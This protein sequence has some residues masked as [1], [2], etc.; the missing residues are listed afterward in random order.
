MNDAFLPNEARLKFTAILTLPDAVFERRAALVFVRKIYI[1]FLASR[2]AL[3]T[4]NE[5]SVWHWAHISLFKFEDF[6]RFLEQ[7]GLT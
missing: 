4:Q 2:I 3:K 1:I 5:I 6:N 7:S